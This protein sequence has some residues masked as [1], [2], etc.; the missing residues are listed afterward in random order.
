MSGNNFRGTFMTDLY[1]NLANK[2]LKTASAG[3]V[4]QAI[5][6]DMTLSPVQ[7]QDW[8][9]LMNTMTT[10]KNMSD[11]CKILSGRM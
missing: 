3:L 6:E 11:T 4:Q 5:L 8:I 7:K 2:C 10:A 9:S 1:S